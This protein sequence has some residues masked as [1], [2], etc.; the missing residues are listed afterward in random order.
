M[1]HKLI[2]CP[3]CGEEFDAES[4]LTDQITERVK[5]E[6]KVDQLKLDK[7]RHEFEA[8]TSKA[9]E[10]YQRT[11]DE[12]IE[13]R[14]KKREEEMKAKLY[15]EH[16]LENKAKDEELA[17]KSKALQEFHK[18]KAENDKLKR[19]KDEQASEMKSQ[20]EIQTAAAVTEA[21]EEQGKEYE[22]KLRDKDKKLDAAERNADET[23]AKIAQGSVKD[24]GTV[25][26]ESVEDWLKREFPHDEIQR[27]NPGV[28]GADVLQT[29][30]APG[31]QC[32]GSMCYESKRTKKFEDKWV[33][34]LRQDMLQKNADVGIIVTQSMPADLDR[35]GV[36]KGVWVCRHH[37]TRFNIS[38]DPPS[39]TGSIWSISKIA[40]GGVLPQY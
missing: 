6:L 5:D 14:V 2:N 23:I 30:F 16:S 28:R 29:V 17:E 11:L 33:D 31:G 22:L 12:G 1:N 26:E 34:K 38:F 20:S 19:E 18:M 4:T 40:S 13:E 27:T 25:Q 32:C 35:P 21:L 36:Y 10:A 24:Q 3:N 7:D 37:V 39:A 15:E 9:R 8:K